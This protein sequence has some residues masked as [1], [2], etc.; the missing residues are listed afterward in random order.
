MYSFLHVFSRVNSYYWDI[1]PWFYITLPVL[2]SAPCLQR[3]CRRHSHG[4]RQEDGSPFHLFHC[5]SRK[6]SAHHWHSYNILW[7]V[8]DYGDFCN[9]G[10]SFKTATCISNTCF[11]DW[12]A[13]WHQALFLSQAILWGRRSEKASAGTAPARISFSWL[14]TNQATSSPVLFLTILVHEVSKHVA[15]VL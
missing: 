5:R 2:T 3:H 11:K 15:C 12:S 6:K 13:V 1:F 4:G 8:T 10:F 7:F 9:G 14:A